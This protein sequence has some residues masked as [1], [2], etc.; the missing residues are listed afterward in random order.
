[1]PFEMI[2]DHQAGLEALSGVAIDYGYEDDFSHIPD[3]SRQF[4]DRLLALHVPVVVEGYHGDHN[5][6]VPARWG[7]A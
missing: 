5:N 2:R 1:M 3:T 7:P 4:A 6:R